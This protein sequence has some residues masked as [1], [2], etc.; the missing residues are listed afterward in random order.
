LVPTGRLYV[1]PRKF[2]RRHGDELLSMREKETIIG[3]NERVG[4][5]L[6]K[7]RVGRFDVAFGLNP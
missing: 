3:N 5:L 2:G 4:A 7:R 6:G 1:F